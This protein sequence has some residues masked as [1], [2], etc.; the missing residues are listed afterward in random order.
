[1]TNI[2]PLMQAEAADDKYRDIVSRCVAGDEAA[3]K[4]LYDQHADALYNISWRLLNNQADAEDMVQETF[5]D[6]FRNISGFE[7]RSSFSTWLKRIL[8][9]RCINFLKKKKL[10][11]IELKDSHIEKATAEEDASEEEIQWEITKILKG[12]ELLPPN[13][14]VVISLY[15]LEGYDHE[16]IAKI[17]N[18][19]EATI[20]TQ[21]ARGKRKLVSIIKNEMKP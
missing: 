2:P 17:T 4:K 18:T 21:Y 12:I 7:S 14:R 16:E 5:V 6:A 13:Y 9:H 8:I 3:Y 19:P 10:H 20:R 11:F 15:L 1:M